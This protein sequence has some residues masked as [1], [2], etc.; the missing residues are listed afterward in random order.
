M[1]RWLHLLDIVA[2]LQDR[3]ATISL[4]IA[5]IKVDSGAKTATTTVSPEVPV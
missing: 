5:E 3:L 4:A 2:E 1:H